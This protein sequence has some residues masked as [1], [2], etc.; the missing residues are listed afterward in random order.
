[1]LDGAADLAAAGVK[2]GAGRLADRP[3]RRGPLVI[4][5]YG[6]AVA[7]R[8]LIA[9]T[10]AA[11]QVIGLRVTDRLGKGLRGPPRDAIIADVTAPALRGRAFAVQR[12]L[13]HVGAVLG[14][15]AAWG[16][17]TSGAAGVRGVIVA[18]LVPGVVVLVLAVWAA[19]DWQTWTGVAAAAPTDSTTTAPAPLRLSPFLV[20]ISSF[21]ALRMPET[22]II[23]RAQ[24]LG[25][26]LALVPL[27][28]AG[29]HVVRA[30]TSFLG[31]VLADRV[32]AARAMWL[33]WVA[34]AALAAG[35]A[36]AESAPHAWALFLTLGV[37][38]GL[39]ESPERALVAH[40]AGPRRGTGFGAYHGAILS[41][42]HASALVE[43]SG[44]GL[45][46]ETDPG[47][48]RYPELDFR[49]IASDMVA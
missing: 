20:A 33:G 1:V 29:L 10:G 46:M 48:G 21:H 18:S 16:L 35:F 19:R 8:P 37:V 32:G 7:V 38:A 49:K 43:L 15:L 2:L 28:W 3:A 11:W 25:V 5:G 12:G 4:A 45:C 31:G 23:L 36:V 30:S 41:G 13:D 22:L 40:A 9:L 14:P 39:T 27:L 47:E 44:E 24:Q 17:L 6:A 26:A 34:Y 42:C